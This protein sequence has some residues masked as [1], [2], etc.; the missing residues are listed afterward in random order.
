MRADGRLTDPMIE[1]HLKASRFDVEALQRAYRRDRKPID[2]LVARNSAQA[3][4]FGFPG[5]PAYLVGTVAFPG[6]LTVQDFQQ[7]IR[8]ALAKNG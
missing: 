4:A 3:E 1:P 6:V 7:A 5:T 2:A 8:D